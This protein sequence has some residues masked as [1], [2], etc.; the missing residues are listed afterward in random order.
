MH[1][2]AECLG[3][4]LPPDTPAAPSHSRYSPKSS[5]RAPPFVI[6]FSVTIF[7]LIRRKWWGDLGLGFLERERERGA[8]VPHDG[9]KSKD[10]ERWAARGSRAKW[11]FHVYFFFKN[12][13]CRLICTK[14]NGSGKRKQHKLKSVVNLLFMF[15]NGYFELEGESI[16]IF[17]I[18]PYSKVTGTLLYFSTLSMLKKL[19]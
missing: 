9:V 1:A 19:F 16:G 8:P 17:V 14:I 11:S 5:P 15:F 6:Y 7:R 2:A 12:Y 3:T 10:R 18:S 13:F 4:S